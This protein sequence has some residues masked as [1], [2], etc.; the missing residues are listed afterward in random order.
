MLILSC[1]HVVKNE[2][3]ILTYEI[4]T[5][6]CALI[7]RVSTHGKRKNVQSARIGRLRLNDHR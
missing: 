5:Y 1:L 7:I 2:N 4:N 3:K 6:I